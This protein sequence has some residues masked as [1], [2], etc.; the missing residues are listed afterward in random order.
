[1]PLEP[2]VDT[3]AL[4]DGS[5]PVY[6]LESAIYRAYCK[7][8]RRQ[9]DEALMSTGV[10]KKQ[11][12]EKPDVPKWKVREDVDLNAWRKNDLDDA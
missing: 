2:L 1:M 4:E 9:A 3:E 10:A 12:K 8:K 11:E 7:E 6:L 5:T